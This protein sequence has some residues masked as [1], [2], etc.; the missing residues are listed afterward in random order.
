MMNNPIKTFDAERAASYDA[1]APVGIPG[2]VH[3]L[4]AEPRHDAATLILVL[5][6]LPE[7][8]SIQAR[9]P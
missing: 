9:I 1:R 6:F 3:E 7:I 8:G 4:P 2:Y 5:Q